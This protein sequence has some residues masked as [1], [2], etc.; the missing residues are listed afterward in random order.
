MSKFLKI[1]QKTV[2]NKDR[3]LFADFIDG[4]DNRCY[5]QV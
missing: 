1:K 2:L 4:S 3:I 5:K